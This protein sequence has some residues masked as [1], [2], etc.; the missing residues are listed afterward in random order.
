M[1]DTSG[2]MTIGWLRQAGQGCHIVGRA[3]SDLNGTLYLAFVGM[4]IPVIIWMAF[5]DGETSWTF[6]GM[7]VFCLLTLVVMFALSSKNRKTALPLVH[8]IE[9]ATGGRSSH[10]F[11]GHQ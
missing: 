7:L 5:R 8:L 4:L 9:T 10:E 11:A 1:W 2:P 6:N 3:G